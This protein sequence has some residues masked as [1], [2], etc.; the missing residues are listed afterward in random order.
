MIENI[1]LNTLVRVK[2]TV[3]PTMAIIRIITK[4]TTPTRAIRVIETKGIRDMEIRV[5]RIMEAKDIKIGT[6]ATKDTQAINQ[7]INK[8]IIQEIKVIHKGIKVINKANTKVIN[9]TTTKITHPIGLII[10]L[11]KTLLIL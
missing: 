6:K 8:A 3:L 5:G 11:S 10:K 2:I 4:T 7:D 1:T 9:K